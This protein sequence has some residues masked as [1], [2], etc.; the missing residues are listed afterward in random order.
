MGT[1][2]QLYIGVPVQNEAEAVAIYNQLDIDIGEDGVFSGTGKEVTVSLKGRKYEVY[3][4]AMTD[5]DEMESFAVGFHLTD[6]YEGAIL[7]ADSKWPDGNPRGRPETFVFDPLD[8]VEV[9]KDVRKWWPQAQVFIW[10][11]AY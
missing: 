4:S 11:V 5:E 3:L 7:D 10:D 9:L 6:R 2:G 1:H 8:I